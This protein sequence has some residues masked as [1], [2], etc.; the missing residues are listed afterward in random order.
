MVI[1]EICAAR[2][3]DQPWATKFS[4]TTPTAIAADQP[5]SVPSISVPIANATIE[6]GSTNGVMLRICS[7]LGAIALAFPFTESQVHEVDRSSRSED[8]PHRGEDARGDPEQPVGQVADASPHDD[9][10]DQRRDDR[11]PD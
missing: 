9:P 1:G 2:A 11:P 4:V 8:D 7:A 5:A 6:S 10:P 3:S